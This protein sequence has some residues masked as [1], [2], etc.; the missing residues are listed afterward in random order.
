MAENA[1]IQPARFDPSQFYGQGNPGSIF[2][3][4]QGGPFTSANAGQ[5]Y[6]GAGAYGLPEAYT[7]WQ[8]AARNASIW[9]GQYAQDINPAI[10]SAMS[11]LGQDNYGKLYA[12]AADTYEGQA[13]GARQ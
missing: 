10:Q 11:R 9:A 2:Q 4:G 3:S 5:Q 12:Q 1:S 13:R 6:Q 7:G 8:P